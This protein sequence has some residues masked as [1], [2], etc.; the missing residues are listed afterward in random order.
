MTTATVRELRMR[1]PRI[2]ALIERDGEIL[3][4]DR[5]RPA[6]LLRAYRPPATAKAEPVDHYAR[7]RSHQPH[8]LTRAAARALDEADRGER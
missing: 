2:K 7:L 8:P 3:V 6:Y 5:G 4:T 1:F